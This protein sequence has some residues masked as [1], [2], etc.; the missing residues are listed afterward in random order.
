MASTLEERFDPYCELGLENYDL[1]TDYDH[2]LEPESAKMRAP[3][4]GSE[5]ESALGKGARSSAE[6]IDELFTRMQPH[7]RK[8]LSIISF[9][10]DP[11]SEAELKTMVDKLQ[12]HDF[13]VFTSS[14]LAA[15]LERAGAIERI[16]KQSGGR[17]LQKREPEIIVIDGTEYY[18]PADRKP[19]FW[20]STP[21]GINALDSDEPL[22][23]LRKLFDEE[24]AYLPI[25]KRLLD[26]CSSNGRSATAIERIVKG[27]PLVENPHKEAAHFTDRLERCDAIRWTGSW[28]TTEIGIQGLDLLADIE[29]SF[30]PESEE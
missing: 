10:R 3:L 22:E 1:I 11:R 29:D 17:S 23:R 14:N 8:L 28:V 9:L 16:D 19:V 7:R 5:A 25:Y 21:A 24:D 15:A 2:G 6:L 26:F 12:E 20:I 30:T 18:K 27:D 13:S 4:E